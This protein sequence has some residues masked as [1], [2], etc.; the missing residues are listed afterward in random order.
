MLFPTIGH[1]NQR[2]MKLQK[3]PPLH[4]MAGFYRAKPGLLKFMSGMGKKSFLC[5]RKWL[6]RPI[7]LFLTFIQ[8]ILTGT[9]ELFMAGIQYAKNGGYVDLTTS[10]IPQF[11]EEGEVK[12]SKGLKMMLDAGVPIENITFSSD[13]QGSLPSFNRNGELI[14]LQVGKVSSLYKEARDAV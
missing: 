12:C 4:E 2:L 6:I 14:G 3:L 8:P 11:L 7:F 1:L 5:S 9:E 10:T 13:G